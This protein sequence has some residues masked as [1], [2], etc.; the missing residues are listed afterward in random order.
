MK[1][2]KKKPVRAMPER[3]RNEKSQRIRLA[4]L[5]LV[6]FGVYLRMGVAPVGRVISPKQNAKSQHVA[7]F[8]FSVSCPR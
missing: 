4:W 1:S 2:P 5:A 7:G 3:A 8:G 6:N